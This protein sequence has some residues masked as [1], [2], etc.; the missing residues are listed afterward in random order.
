MTDI[1]QIALD[2]ARRF[3]Q[4]DEPQRRAQLQVAV[5]EAIRAGQA[6]FPLVDLLDV[7][8]QLHVMAT[9]VVP[10]FC[11]LAAGLQSQVQGLIDVHRR[12][13]QP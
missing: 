7:R 11:D 13:E 6:P 9:T 1:D 12:R 10:N 4:D 2:V 8:N 5:V 3:T